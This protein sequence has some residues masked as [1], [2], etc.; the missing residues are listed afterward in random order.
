MVHIDCPVVGNETRSTKF[1]HEVADAGSRGTDHCR[2][3]FL[4]YGNRYDGR[5]AF[6]SIISEKQKEAREPL[7]ARINHIRFDLAIPVQQM[8]HK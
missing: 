7:L 3:R 4:T 2:E 8:V 5:T 1:V 6:F